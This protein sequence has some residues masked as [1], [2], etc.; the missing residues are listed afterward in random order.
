[1]VALAVASD[2]DHQFLPR[3]LVIMLVVVATAND[4][5]KGTP[6]V[7]VHLVTQLNLLITSKNKLFSKPPIPNSPKPATASQK[8][9]LTPSETVT[10]LK[11]RVELLNPAHPHSLAL[12]SNP[13]VPQSQTPLILKPQ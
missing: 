6:I 1:M 8:P 10:S 5:L 3:V 7:S 4:Q 13:P 9:S 12:W 2:L 11:L